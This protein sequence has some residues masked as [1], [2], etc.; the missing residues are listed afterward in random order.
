[1]WKLINE[2]LI[3]MKAERSV[4]AS[5]F[6][7]LTPADGSTSATSMLFSGLTSPAAAPARA[8]GGGV[9]APARTPGTAATAPITIDM[10]APEGKTAKGFSPPS[11]VPP[12]GTPPR[13]ASAGSE[14]RAFSPAPTALVYPPLPPSS[15][16]PRREEEG[17]E[18]SSGS[19]DA[20][21]EETLKRLEALEIRLEA[22][23]GNLSTPSP[24]PH[25]DLSASNL[26]VPNGASGE[27][28]LFAPLQGTPAGGAGVLN[29][30]VQWKEVI[31]DALIEGEPFPMAFPVV[32]D[33]TG[34]SVWKALDWKILK[35]AKSAVTQYGLKSSYAQSV[36]QHI[37]SSQLLAPYDIRMIVQVAAAA[38]LSVLA[39]CL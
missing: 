3:S 25:R 8:E 14:S 9:R 16:P 10:R 39:G 34:K 29:P 22:S 18:H 15:L 1:M 6:A 35:E 12:P 24:V 30:I 33:N 27:I 4:A 2:T 19:K 7:A 26:F 5:A 31:R 21:L 13:C 38:V 36:L 20:Q 37:F 32:T 28:S 17:D 23:L 11:D